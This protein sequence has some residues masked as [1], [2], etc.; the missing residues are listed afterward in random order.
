MAKKEKKAK[1]PA[2]QALIREMIAM[3]KP[4]TMA[5]VQS[6]LRD[7][8][9]ST[10]EEMLHAELDSELGYQKHDQGPKETTNRRNGS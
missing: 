9:S 4:E 3:Y 7:M 2:K 5:D 8:F 10:I 6:I 1:D